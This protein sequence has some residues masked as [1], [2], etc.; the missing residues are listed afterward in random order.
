MSAAE[1]GGRAAHL[2][3]FALLVRD[4][5]LPHRKAVDALLRRD[6]FTHH[7]RSSA[8]PLPAGY[9]TA[10][11]NAWLVDTGRLTFGE[12]AYLVA[13][14]LR[15]KGAAD[16]DHAMNRAE[17]LLSHTLT[18]LGEQRTRTGEELAAAME[19]LKP[20]EPPQPRPR[21]VAAR[22]VRLGGMP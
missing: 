14:T 3:A 22:P 9:S 2:D 19:R 13:R 12:G 5:L 10:R 20:Q 16:I 17:K 21:P 7:E 18:E 1:E 6:Y 8:T 15:A 11:G 4:G